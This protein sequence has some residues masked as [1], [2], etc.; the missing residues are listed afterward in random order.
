MK[1]I[2]L[3]LSL[4]LILVQNGFAETDAEYDKIISEQTLEVDK[5][6]W[7]CN[8]AALKHKYTSDPKVCIKALEL[9]KKVYPDAKNVIAILHTSIGILYYHNKKDYVKTYE[10]FMKA[11]KLGNT[12]A[13]R[14]L[15]ILCRE[16]SWVCK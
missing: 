6:L 13:Q 16:H 8:K 7:R 10:Y 11:A 2:I 1:R 5:Q 3:G 4:L 15:D 9:E 12:D 14:N